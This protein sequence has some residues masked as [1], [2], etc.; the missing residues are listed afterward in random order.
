M[1]ELF[2]LSAHLFALLAKLI[3]AGGAK[4]VVAENLVLKQQLLIIS[5]SRQ[6]ALNL[7]ATD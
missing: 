2:L 3:G 6:H 4:S 7:S 5:R 1:K